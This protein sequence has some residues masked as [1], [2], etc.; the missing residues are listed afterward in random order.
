MYDAWGFATKFQ[1]AR[2]QYF[3]GFYCDDLADTVASCEL[4]MPT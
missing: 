3:G 4:M 2:L 1:N